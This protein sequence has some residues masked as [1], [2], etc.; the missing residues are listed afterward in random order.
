MPGDE[1]PKGEV[2]QLSKDLNLLPLD[3]DPTVS[4]LTNFR[5]AALRAGQA[6]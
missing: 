2:E 4:I 5:R 3:L 6:S 1:D